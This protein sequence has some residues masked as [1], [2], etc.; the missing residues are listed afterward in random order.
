M[1]TLAKLL[2]DHELLLVFLVVMG[3]VLLGRVTLFGT[4]LGVA[5]VLFTGIAVS[6]L[7]GTASS[8]LAITPILLLNWWSGVG[9]GGRLK[10]NSSNPTTSI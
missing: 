9:K 7:V 5:G 10:I 2:S 8:P 6:A 3:G 4:R 1:D